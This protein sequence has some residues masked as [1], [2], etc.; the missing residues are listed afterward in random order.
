MTEWDEFKDFDWENVYTKIKKPA[1]I[2][3]G[4]NILNMN[5]ISKIGFNYFGL[6]RR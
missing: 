6:G 4:R 1:F 5:K 3:D 2:F